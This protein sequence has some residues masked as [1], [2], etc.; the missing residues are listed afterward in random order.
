M[1]RH[2]R[3][4]FQLVALV[5]PHRKRSTVRLIFMFFACL[6]TELSLHLYAC[7][8]VYMLHILHDCYT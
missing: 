6:D 7:M 5:G 8:Y 2:G 3:F 1:V 4:G